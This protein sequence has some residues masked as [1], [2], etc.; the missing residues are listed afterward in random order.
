MEIIDIE[1]NTA[2][3]ETDYGV[4]WV[5]FDLDSDGRIVNATIADYSPEGSDHAMPP[6]DELILEEAVSRIED[7]LERHQYRYGVNANKEVT[8]LLVVRRQNKAYSVKL[9]DDLAE[10]DTELFCVL[11]GSP[12]ILGALRKPLN[13]LVSSYYRSSKVPDDEYLESLIKRL[14]RELSRLWNGSDGAPHLSKENLPNQLPIIEQ[15]TAAL[16]ASTMILTCAEAVSNV[17]LK[18][19]LREGTESGFYKLRVNQR[20]RFDTER[21]RADHPD[22]YQKYLISS[23]TEVLTKPMTAKLFPFGEQELRE[24]IDVAFSLIGNISRNK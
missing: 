19:F 7:E 12:Q 4:Y 10:D 24:H 16:W 20:T 22:L 6:S 1:G 17:M 11:D 14:L 9:E 8:R 5:S 18:G 2:E 3:F 21:F 13:T 15:Q 23:K